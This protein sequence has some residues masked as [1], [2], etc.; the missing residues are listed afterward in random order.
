MIDM[1]GGAVTAT[2][3]IESEVVRP[4][5]TVNVLLS[6]ALSAE[7]ED[8]RIHQRFDPPVLDDVSIESADDATITVVA[9]DNAALFASW[10]GVSEV[11]LSYRLTISEKAT[12]DATYTISGRIEDAE[13][14]DTVHTIDDVPIVSPIN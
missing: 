3:T 12:I 6:V 10:G 2:Q 14:G 13:S 4:G 11:T 5:E 9:D 8:L 7:S 1:M